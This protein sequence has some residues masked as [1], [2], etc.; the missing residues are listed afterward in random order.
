MDSRR[1]LGNDTN[2]PQPI[3]CAISADRKSVRVIH[4]DRTG[5][6]LCFIHSL[7][8]DI[9]DIELIPKF[10]P[11]GAATTVATTVCFCALP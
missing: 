9:P 10:K 7:Y 4:K 8:I 6:S 2:V 5:I 3:T 11:L 1:N